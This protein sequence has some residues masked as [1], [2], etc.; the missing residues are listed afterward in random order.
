MQS[1]QGFVT[2]IS[3]QSD[4]ILS[5]DTQ[6][7]L[8]LWSLHGIKITSVTTKCRINDSCLVAKKVAPESLIKSNI[9]I[10]GMY[11]TSVERNVF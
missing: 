1:H 7:M 3:C 4:Y 2:S 9:V 6:G 11:K 8:V 5:T 10:E